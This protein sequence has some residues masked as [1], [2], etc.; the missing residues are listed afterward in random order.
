M[1]PPCVIVATEVLPAVRALI[2]RN[3]VLKHGLKRSEVA[4]KLGLTPAAVSQY[5]KLKRGRE[6][7]SL[8][9]RSERAMKLIEEFSKSLSERDIDSSEEMKLVCRICDVLREDGIIC[10]IHRRDSPELEECALCL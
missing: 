8:L 3:L 10:E 4:R 2:A 7:I 6:G 9:E 5:L 1:K